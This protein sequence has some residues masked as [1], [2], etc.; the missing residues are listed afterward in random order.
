MLFR[1]YEV[2]TD[3][4]WNDKVAVVVSTNRDSAEKLK[5]ELIETRQLGKDNVEQVIIEEITLS[6]ME[7]LRQ[8][9]VKASGGREITLIVIDAVNE[10]EYQMLKE[11]LQSLAVVT[12]AGSSIN[13]TAE[14]QRVTEECV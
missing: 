6:R 9:V 12:A 5:E 14:W 11:N 8:K 10:D 1:S 7:E 3:E 4:F 13:N 2:V